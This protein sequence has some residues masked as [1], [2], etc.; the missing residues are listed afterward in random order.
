MVLFIVT[1]DHPD[2]AGWQQQLMPHIAWLQERIRD[3]ALLASGPFSE[4]AVK[5]ALLIMS[6]PD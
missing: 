6:A 4:V 5:S 2:E 1:Y 3:G